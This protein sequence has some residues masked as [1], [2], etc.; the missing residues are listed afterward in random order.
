[1]AMHSSQVGVLTDHITTDHSKAT[2]C[3]WAVYYELA[4][5]SMM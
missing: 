1:M 2:I 4:N 5:G 3:V